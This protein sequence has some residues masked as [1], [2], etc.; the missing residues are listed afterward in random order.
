VLAPDAT[1]VVVI[2][3]WRGQAPD[4]PLQFRDVDGHWRSTTWRDE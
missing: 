3:L 2:D 4:P 1:R